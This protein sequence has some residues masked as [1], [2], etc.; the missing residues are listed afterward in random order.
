[1]AGRLNGGHRVAGLMFHNS[2]LVYMELIVPN[3]LAKSQHDIFISQQKQGNASRQHRP[4]GKEQQMRAFEGRQILFE[5]GQR[6]Y[7]M[8]DQHK[9]VAEFFIQTCQESGQYN[10][11]D[12]SQYNTFLTLSTFII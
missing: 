2:F 12:D 6:G 7:C 4:S 8:D 3:R 10:Q 9:T 1:M 11:L 5:R